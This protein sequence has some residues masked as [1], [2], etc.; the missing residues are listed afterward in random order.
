VG[1]EPVESDALS[2]TDIG[3]DTGTPAIT[4]KTSRIVVE[5]SGPKVVFDIGYRHVLAFRTA[6]R[7]VA[8]TI[9]NGLEDRNVEKV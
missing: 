2:R 5:Y 6:S 1:A 9:A 4:G 8:E 3:T 7:D